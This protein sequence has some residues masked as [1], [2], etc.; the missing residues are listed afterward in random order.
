MIEKDER[1]KKIK[2]DGSAIVPWMSRGKKIN[3]DGFKS[4]ARKMRCAAR[5]PTAG[6]TPVAGMVR[7]FPRETGSSALVASSSR[8]CTPQAWGSRIQTLAPSLFL[9]VGEFSCKV[10]AL[11]DEKRNTMGR[12]AQELPSRDSCER[13]AL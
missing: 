8:S 3:T 5:V 7:M 9:V 6:R 10:G 11:G 1:K 12:Q 4:L 2:A 13:D